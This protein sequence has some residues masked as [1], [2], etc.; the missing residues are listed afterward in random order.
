MSNTFSARLNANGVPGIRPATLKDVDRIAGIEAESFSDAWHRRS[1]VQLVDD[2]RVFF[3]VATRPDGGVIGYIVAWFVADEGEIANVA[4]APDA[5]GR[6]VGTALLDDAMSAA[7][8][9]GVAALYLDVRESNTAARA[10]YASR[11]FAEVGRRRGYYRRPSEDG[12]ILR[13]S[14]A[15]SHLRVPVR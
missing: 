14:T 7:A 4:V 3:R 6:G 5:R 9:L 11:G 15:A 2:G 10:L 12:L 1:F 13:C 8:G